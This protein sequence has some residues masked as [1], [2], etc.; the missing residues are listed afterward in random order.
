MTSH[1][2]IAGRRASFEIRLGAVT[3]SVDEADSKGTRG[4]AKVLDSRAEGA[5]AVED[6]DLDRPSGVSPSQPSFGR[7]PPTLAP[8]GWRISLINPSPLRI[9]SKLFV[10]TSKRRWLRIRRYMW[11]NFRLPE[12]GRFASCGAAAQRLRHH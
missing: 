6:A 4:Y 3:E 1:Y 11:R 8:P 9:R 10:A 5:V 7:A 2:Q 12:C